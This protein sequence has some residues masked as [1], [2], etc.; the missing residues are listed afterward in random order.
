M[1]PRTANSARRTVLSGTAG[2]IM[3]RG[4]RTASKN[5]EARTGW[6][7][8]WEDRDDFNPYFD[9][10]WLL[11][12][13]S[14]EILRVHVEA[15]RAGVN[16]ATGAPIPRLNPL[17]RSGREARAGKRP[18]VRGI[19]RTDGRDLASMLTRSKIKGRTAKIG[20][21]RAGSAASCK[22]GAGTGGHGKYLSK[23]LDDHGVEHLE[24]SEKV[25]TAIDQAL[26]MWVAA[27]LQGPPSV[28]PN[29]RD[30]RGKD[31]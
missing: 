5:Y 12:D 11:A 24:I 31:L 8:V 30:L 3:V 18:D 2:A 4:R 29:F 26:T 16:P 23:A 14:A 13:V 19:A 15:L 10:S 6:G 25:E 28:F 20:K 22:I 9:A 21:G 7:I 1:P 17:G 27:A